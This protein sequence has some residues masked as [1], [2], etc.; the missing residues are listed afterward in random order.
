MPRLPKD[1]PKKEK[2][3]RVK[4]EMHKFKNEE[5]K[6]STGEKVT[7]PKQAVAIALSEAGESKKSK[8]AKQ[9]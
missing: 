1:A 3:N 6:S 9:K 8:K 7:N 2:Q 5:L 4:E